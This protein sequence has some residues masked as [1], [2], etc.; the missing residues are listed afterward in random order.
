MK[1]QCLIAK[2]IFYST[3]GVHLKASNKEKPKTK[4]ALTNESKDVSNG[5]NE[6]DED[7]SEDQKGQGDGRVAEPAE[8]F[9]GTQQLRDGAADLQE[10]DSYLSP[11]RSTEPHPKPFPP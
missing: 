11:R 8:F 9:L 6:D 1:H 4:R 3:V 2:L 10:E 5:G 7:V